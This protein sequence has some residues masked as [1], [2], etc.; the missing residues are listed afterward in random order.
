MAY[1][2]GQDS[3]IATGVPI[4]KAEHL[5]FKDCGLVIRTSNVV[6]RMPQP[7]DGE[8]VDGCPVVCL[9]D[10]PIDT[11]AFLRAIFDSEFFEPYPSETDFDAI[12]GVLKFSNKYLV[13]YL[14]RRALVHLSSRYPM[15]LDGWMDPTPPSWRIEPDLL[16]P[17][18]NLA[19]EVSALWILPVVFYALVM[20]TGIVATQRS[21]AYPLEEYAG[22]VLTNSLDPAKRVAKGTL[23]LPTF[24]AYPI[25]LK[26][27]PEV[28][29]RRSLA[30]EFGANGFAKWFLLNA[31]VTSRKL[32]V[33]T[34][35]NELT[36]LE[37]VIT[38]VEVGHLVDKGGPVYRLQKAPYWTLWK[39]LDDLRNRAKV[40]YE[41]FNA[42]MPSMPT[43]GRSEDPLAFYAAND[44]EILGICYRVE[45]ENYL[46]NLDQHFDF[47]T[48]EI[49]SPDEEIQEY[50]N[51][52]RRSISVK[53]KRAS[54]IPDARNSNSSVNESFA[55]L[56][57][58]STPRPARGSSHRV[59][60][61]EISDKSEDEDV[62]LP[63]QTAAPREAFG[64]SSTPPSKFH[65][66]F[67]RIRFNQDMQSH[68]QS[69]RIRNRLPEGIHSDGRNRELPPHLSNLGFQIPNHSSRP[70]E[71]SHLR[72]SR[73]QPMASG[74][75]DPESDPSDSDD[76]NGK[77]GKDGGK[78]PRPDPKGPGKPPR[79][80]G[81]AGGNPDDDPSSSDDEGGDRR[82]GIPRGSRRPAKKSKGTRGND[83]SDDDKDNGRYFDMRLK[84]SDVPKWD[85][86]PDTLLRWIQRCNLIAE[87]GPKAWKQLGKIV[88]RVLTGTAQ[89]WYF[90]LPLDYQRKIRENWESMRQALADFFL[91]SK[92]LDKTRT[93]ALRANYRQTG[94]GKEKPSEYFIRKRELLN[95][96]YSFEDSAIMS[97]VMNGAPRSWC[98]VLDT[99]KYRNI[100]EFHAAIVFHEDT[101]LDLPMNKS[102]DYGKQ[103]YF[104]R[105]KPFEKTNAT[106]RTNLV[107]ISSTLPPPKFP[108]DD[109]NISKKATPESKGARPCRHC[110]SG[111]H[112][113][114]ECKYSFK[115]N[116]FARTNLAVATTEDITAQ[117]EYDE[118]YYGLDEASS[119]DE[120]DF[121]QPL[122]STGP[123]TFQASADLKSGGNIRP[124]LK[125][126]SEP[127]NSRRAHV[128]EVDDEEDN[129]FSKLHPLSPFVILEEVED[130]IP[131]TNI[132]DTL[133]EDIPFDTPS[134]DD[135][136][137]L[138]HA[139]TEVEEDESETSTP[140]P[141]SKP[142]LNRRTRRRLAKEIGACSYRVVSSADACALKPLIELRKHMARPPGSTFLGAR[143]TEATAT[144]GSLTTDPIII[145]VDSGSDIT[146]IS[147]KALNSLSNP[148]KIKQGHQVN[149]IQVTETSSISGYVNLDLFFVTEDGPVKLNVDA[150]VVD[151]MTTPFLF[152]ND[153]ADQYSLSI[154]REEGSTYLQFGD[155][156]R[157]L[158]VEN[159]TSPPLI[160]GNGHAFEV[161]CAR[162]RAKKNSKPAIHRRNQK[163]RQRSRKKERDG[164]V[165]STERVVIPAKTSKLVKVS[166]HFPKDCEQLIVERLLKS[167]GNV[168]D[169][170]G[171]ADTFISK[172]KPALHIAN[173]SDFP[174]IVSEGQV[175]G[176]AHNPRTWLDKASKMSPIQKQRAE[177]HANFI[178]QLVETQSSPAATP[179]PAESSAIRSE[180]NISSKAH[181]NATGED[182]PGAEEPVE[183][184]PKTA[185]TPPEF[186]DSSKLLEQID[187][188]K[189][190]T[191]E[192]CKMLE[193]VVIKNATAFGL[194][195]RLGTYQEQVVIPMKPGAKPVSLPP[196]PCITSET[197]IH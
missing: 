172:D 169:I 113:D 185:E 127:K 21:D 32:F 53:P 157:R 177:A 60:V 166:T 48:N 181:R 137:G 85:G 87:D 81:R 20:D 110:G 12:H 122:Q 40:A 117:E 8:T 16:I 30:L 102:E 146:L 92:W 88:P 145:I 49:R 136:P 31:K 56:H 167:C 148:P 66:A 176:T 178:R 123:S 96:V 121:D 62:V 39:Q 154:I 190:V 114:N 161:R 171:S 115:S 74:D 68:H 45:V 139:E 86:N 24:Q 18:I 100:V 168:D 83:S 162:A 175:V 75:V 58:V 91:S 14:R 186:V 67:G 84:D 34:F 65:E 106:A 124:A 158:P 151:D 129:P 55:Q 5:W 23:N 89:D 105:R 163:F 197:R 188:S 78:R 25:I 104:D 93:K 94:H 42:D 13:D 170:Y 79:G 9:P 33:S 28:L 189:A 195:G 38:S 3:S 194:D 63:H 52:H 77:K 126:N 71:S 142:P 54:S 125:G 132:R 179:V 47:A 101:L 128:K 152:G 111:K 51:E 133:A 182:D 107:G 173:F 90:S 109:N 19:R 141:C 22:P 140:A 143:A 80:P 192:Q 10:D 191:P 11:T 116:K 160:D 4:R 27:D 120:Q 17:A 59:R 72:Q 37:T 50:Y 69:K 147:R 70:S 7:S 130:A 150:Y 73:A 61:E 196:F 155:S 15:T 164:R 44:Y 165:F 103:D 76:N 6:F 144:V 64:K 29:E 183:G 97:E 174:V 156:G 82:H 46:A 119:A 98:T 135:S 118:L 95:S 26:G 187:I 153:F 180:S 41:V 112:W 108:K 138:S 99:Q 149:L 2:L 57:P 184:G 43:W 131:T 36:T 134:H 35:R 1:S 159:S 193:D